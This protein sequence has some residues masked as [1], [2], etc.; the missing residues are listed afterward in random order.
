[1]SKTDFQ[2]GFALGLASGGVVE[3]EGVKLNIAYGETAPEDTS[4]LWIKANEPGNVEFITSGDVNPIV[5]HTLTTPISFSMGVCNLNKMYLFR[6][7]AGVYEFNVLSKNLIKISDKNITAGNNNCGR[8]YCNG[9]IY[10]FGGTTNYSSSS[11]SNNIRCYDIATDELTTKNAVLPIAM[12]GVACCVVGDYIYTFGGNNINLQNYICKYDTINDT[13]EI[14][15]YLGSNRAEIATCLIGSKIYLFGGFPNIDIIQ[16]FETTD[17]TLSTMNA[18]LT[19][20]G[21][22]IGVT[23]IGTDVYLVGGE[24]YTSSA[25]LIMKREYIE[26]YDTLTDTISIVL[27]TSEVSGP[28]YTTVT[29]DNQ[30]YFHIGDNIKCFTPGAL[31]LNH[32]NIAIKQNQELYFDIY[33]GIKIGV[34][35]VYIGNV[36]NEAEPVSAYLYNGTEWKQISYGA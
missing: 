14:V 9:K 15:G 3:S 20:G 5:E 28:V 29:Y 1:M 34:K 10:I 25:G 4:K 23:N 31:T 19:N 18:T 8:C 2:N 24:Q 30:I 6:N 16:C 17:N 13:L 35:N 12:W 27:N 36:N 32:G 11:S 22:Y 21:C 33:N 26:K 7:T